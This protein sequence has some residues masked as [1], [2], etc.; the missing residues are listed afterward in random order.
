MSDTVNSPLTF[1]SGGTGWSFR[2]PLRRAT[3]VPSARWRTAGS[4]W[5]TEPGPPKCGAVP[6]NQAPPGRKAHCGWWQNWVSVTN[7][8][9]SSGNP[10]ARL[11]PDNCGWSHLKFLFYVHLIPSRPSLVSCCF[12][13]SSFCLISTR[14]YGVLTPY[15]LKIAPTYFFVNRIFHKSCV[16]FVIL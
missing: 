12:S 15:V 11:S 9:K 13:C 6:D 1:S 3:G 5:G 4:P 16:L 7:T 2:S 14:C 8:W 10:P